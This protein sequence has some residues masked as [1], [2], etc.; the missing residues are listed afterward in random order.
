[1]YMDFYAKI[2]KTHFE[3]S[4]GYLE[5]RISVERGAMRGKAEQSCAM[6]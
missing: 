3:V 5:K 6:L 1:M 2:K 4:A